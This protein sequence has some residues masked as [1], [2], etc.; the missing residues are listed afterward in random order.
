MT[1]TPHNPDVAA[2][3]TLRTPQTKSVRDIGHPRSTFAIF[4]AA[5][6][7]VAMITMLKKKPR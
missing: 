5:R 7:T 3:R 4:A 2:N 6:L 1:S